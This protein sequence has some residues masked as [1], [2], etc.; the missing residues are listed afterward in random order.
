M[1]VYNGYEYFEHLKTLQTAQVKKELNQLFLDLLDW[2]EQSDDE[3]LYIKLLETLAKEYP[4][5]I[6]GLKK[7]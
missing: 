6:P 7:T 2:Y 1:K 5:K 3:E 4:E